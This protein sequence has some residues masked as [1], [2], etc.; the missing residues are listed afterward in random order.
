MS[1]SKPFGSVVVGGERSEGWDAA[2]FVVPD[3]GGEG[4]ESLK[5]AGCDAGEAAG[6][7]PL[8]VELRFEGLIDGLDDLA[9][10]AQEALVGS[11]GFGL[12]RRSDQ[13]G[14][15]FGEGGVEFGRSVALVGDDG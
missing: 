7:V 2:L 3:D 5:D 10:G 11:G 12:E 13:T 15:V 1:S 8:E 14:A 6:G 4:E 9:E